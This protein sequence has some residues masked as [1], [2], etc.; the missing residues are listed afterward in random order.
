MMLI[1][2]FSSQI[3]GAVV[4]DYE[5]FGQPASE[6]PHFKDIANYKPTPLQ[7]FVDGITKEEDKPAPPTAA[8]LA[9]AAKAAAAKTAA[10][11]TATATTATPT[12]TPTPTPA[13]TSRKRQRI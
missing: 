8:A 9:A 5:L 4:S 2:L 7:S 11:T 10:A 6:P 12:P 1:P 3:V 13:T